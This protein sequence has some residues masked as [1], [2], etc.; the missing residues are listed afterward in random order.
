MPNTLE[1]WVP[2]KYEAPVYLESQALVTYSDILQ[3]QTLE[4]RVPQKYE[5][6]VYLE[7]QAL[8]T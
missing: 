8:V 6:P 3:N 4:I 2:Q 1:I 7:P 5:A